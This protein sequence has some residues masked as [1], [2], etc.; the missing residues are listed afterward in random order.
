[1]DEEGVMKTEDNSLLVLGCGVAK[2]LAIEALVK[3]SEIRRGRMN[4]I[5]GGKWV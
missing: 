1:M 3:S 2:L 4:A 5:N